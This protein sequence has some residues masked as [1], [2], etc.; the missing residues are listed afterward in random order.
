MFLAKR[1]DVQLEPC[2]SPYDDPR[3]EGNGVN[4]AGNSGTFFFPEVCLRLTV[5]PPR[6]WPNHISWR[7]L[8]AAGMFFT[9]SCL[10]QL[11][12]GYQE[13]ANTSEVFTFLLH[14]CDYV[15]YKLTGRNIGQ[16]LS[17]RL[18]GWVRCQ[19]TL[20]CLAA[21]LVSFRH[22]HGSWC[23]NHPEPIDS[24]VWFYWSQPRNIRYPNIRLKSR[25]IQY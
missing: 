19:I 3:F 11:Q 8:D 25:H 18:I 20:H 10:Q 4:G 13:F 14:M 24:V 17:T 22:W 16:L 6:V 9:A 5:L 12:H 21:V 7:F 2:I 1:Q 15:E 23:S